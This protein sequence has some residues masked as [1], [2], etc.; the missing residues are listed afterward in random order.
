[1]KCL[2][3]VSVLSL[4]AACAALFATACSSDDN[5]SDSSDPIAAGKAE[6]KEHACES[7]HTPPGNVGTLSGQ[8]DPQP[9]THAYPANLTPDADTG[10]GDWS[11]DQIVKA[12][13]TG[14]DDE[15]ENLCPPMPHFGSQGMTEAEATN[16]AAYLKSLPAVSHEIPESSCAEKGGGE[17]DGG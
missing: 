3:I 8:T 17:E 1:M 12:I 2:S 5:K 4:G 14:V 16:I 11:T 7:C 15:D 9:G 10:M 13:L 6:V